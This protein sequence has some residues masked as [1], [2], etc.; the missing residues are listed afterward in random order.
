M[1]IKITIPYPDPV[2]LPVY[3]W[4]WGAVRARYADTAKWGG[5]LTGAALTAF[6]A[7]CRNDF[8]SL[9]D[10]QVEAILGLQAAPPVGEVT[11]FDVGISRDTFPA[12]DG[13]TA[14]IQNVVPVGA[15]VSSAVWSSS[16]P[17][18]ATVD[19]YGNVTGVKAGTA[20]IIATVSTGAGDVT[21]KVAVTVEPSITSTHRIMAAELTADGAVLGMTPTKGAIAPDYIADLT[22]PASPVY[23]KIH[24]VEANSASGF[25]RLT[26]AD[27]L[28]HFEKFTMTVAGSS[29][30]LT[31]TGNNRW[32][33]PKNA[34]GT[35]F[36]TEV[37]NYFK[38]N[39]GV[40]AG[41]DIVGT[42][43]AP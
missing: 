26:L 35:A 6:I 28:D 13:A 12:G 16:A 3:P 8:P 29:A 37:Y 36:T 42:P 1:G 7:S 31:K 15:D 21:D 40:P 9:R 10:G 4:L 27:N 22:V 34:Q 14:F 33:T 11:A 5:D 41:I 2:L 17:L 32:E 23:A 18:I 30:E 39:L 43:V 20:D 24:A 19:V 38:A 25:I